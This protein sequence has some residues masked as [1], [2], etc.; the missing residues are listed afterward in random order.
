MNVS[1]QG[2]IF[3]IKRLAVMSAIVFLLTVAGCSKTPEPRPAPADAAAPRGPH[4]TYM[5]NIEFAN[6]GAAQGSLE[7]LKKAM[8]GVAT[9]ENGPFPVPGTPLVRFAVSTDPNAP[10]E[11]VLQKVRTVAGVKNVTVVR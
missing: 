1:H 2:G 7:S 10:S 5:L 9:V 4:K 6:V 11:P 8:Q 3:D